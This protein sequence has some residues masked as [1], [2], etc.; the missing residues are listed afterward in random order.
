MTPFAVV[1]GTT[2]AAAGGG[3]LV[4]VGVIIAAAAVPVFVR[5]RVEPVKP[6]SGVFRLRLL[7]WPTSSRRHFLVC[8][9]AK[10]NVPAPCW[11]MPL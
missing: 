8:V 2:L 5:Y 3:G 7:R 9:N 11:S 6:Y 10:S 4:V 1:I